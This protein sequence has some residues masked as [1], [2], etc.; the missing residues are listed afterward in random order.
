MKKGK[1]LSALLSVLAICSYTTAQ[2]PE[3]YYSSL[4]GKKGSSLKN[5]VYNLIKDAEVLSYGSGSGSTWDGFYSTDRLPN[6]QV[7]DRYSNDIRYFT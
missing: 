7:V 5:A 6:N 4:A 1:R 2:I 3:G